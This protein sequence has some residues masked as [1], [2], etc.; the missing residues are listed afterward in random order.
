MVPAFENSISLE[1]DV[2]D[3]LGLLPEPLYKLLTI[4][5]HQKY[6]ISGTSLSIVDFLRF[7]KQSMIQNSMR[8][9]L[10]KVR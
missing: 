1:M 3:S 6:Y 9:F 8:I 7:Q 5:T 4:A 10:K 2:T